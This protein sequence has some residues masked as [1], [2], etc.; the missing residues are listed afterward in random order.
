MLFEDRFIPGL[1]ATTIAFTSY[2]DLIIMIKIIKII[3][4]I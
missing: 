2:I 4:N 1:I 3:K